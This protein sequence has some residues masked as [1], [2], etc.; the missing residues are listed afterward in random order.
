MG[1]RAQI[2][3]RGVI[4]KYKDTDTG[5]VITAQEFQ[6]RQGLQQGGYYMAAPPQQQ[7]MMAVPPA[8]QGVYG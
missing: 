8:H 4:T 2:D 3:D 1:Y 7:Q 6:R 5:E